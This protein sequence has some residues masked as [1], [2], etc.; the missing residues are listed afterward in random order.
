MVTPKR[1]RIGSKDST[2]TAFLCEEDIDANSVIKYQAQK[3][4]RVV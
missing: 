4:S 2:T 3:P 1:M